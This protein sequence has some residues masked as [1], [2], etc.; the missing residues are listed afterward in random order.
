MRWCLKGN[1]LPV[2]EEKGEGS[3]GEGDEEVLDEEPTGEGG[4]GAIHLEDDSG[5]SGVNL[6]HDATDHNVD[7]DG[8][9]I[10]PNMGH[11]QRVKL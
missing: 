2:G 10:Q 6:A 7:A 5:D 4:D 11:L 1:Y 8:D 3:Y 9:T